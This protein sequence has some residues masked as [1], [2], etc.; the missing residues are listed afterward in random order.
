MEPCAYR[1]SS[2]DNFWDKFGRFFTK[3]EGVRY[4]EHEKRLYVKK[5]GNER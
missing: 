4:G 1:H 2:I 5:D 3:M